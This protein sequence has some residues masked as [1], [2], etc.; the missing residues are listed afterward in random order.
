MNQQERERMD[1]LEARIAALEVKDGR[2]GPQTEEPAERDRITQRLVDVLTVRENWDENKA[3]DAPPVD[4]SC[5]VLVSGER[6]PEDRSHTE[7]K[8]DGQQ[9]D[10]VVLCDSERAKGFVRPYRDAYRHLKCGKITTMGRAI[11][12]TYSR[13]PNFYTG[14]FC[15]TCRDHF[16]IGE[17][18]EF[19]WYEMNGS[20][21]PKVGT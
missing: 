12:E 20:T 11:A 8:A 14:T 18:G 21:G 17:A 16:P 7:I 4:R 6:V 15:T 9:K 10:Y 1:A 5:Q 19:V 13:D 2:L 3:K